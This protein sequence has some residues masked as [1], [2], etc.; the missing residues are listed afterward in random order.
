MHKDKGAINFTLNI[1]ASVN[2]VQY[3]S[4]AS[5][6]TARYTLQ[7]GRLEQYEWTFLLK[8]TQP[9]V[10]PHFLQLMWV[11]FLTQENNS[12]Q[13]CLGIKPGSPGL[14]A[15]LEPLSHCCPRMPWATT[16][17]NGILSLVHQ[18]QLTRVI[19]VSSDATGDKTNKSEEIKILYAY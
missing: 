8:E 11:N 4:P 14:Q 7:L 9:L 5:A 2:E 18:W 13:R 17:V 16:K 10:L 12:K 6:S 19:S 3:L 15:D 1:T